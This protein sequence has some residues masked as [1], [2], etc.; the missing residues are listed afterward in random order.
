M[1]IPLFRDQNEQAIRL[2][3]KHL[4]RL[5]A[6]ACAGL[7]SE[8][9]RQYMP[10]ATA[11]FPQV[12]A[13]KHALLAYYHRVAARHRWMRFPVHALHATETPGI[14]LVEYSTIARHHS[15]SV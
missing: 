5:D 11:G 15:G 13:G 3:F 7:L 1:N 12:L 2:Y 9:A 14:F 10:F 4:S 8:Q 6:G